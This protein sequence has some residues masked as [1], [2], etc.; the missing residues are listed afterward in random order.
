MLWLNSI[1]KGNLI[2]KGFILLTDPY[3]SSSVN[4]LKAGT[5]NQ[6]SAQRPRRSAIY[7]LAPIVCSTCFLIKTQ[8]HQSTNPKGLCH[9]HQSVIIPSMVDWRLIFWSHYL[10]CSFH[11]NDLYPE[12][13]WY[14]TAQHIKLRI[15]RKDIWEVTIL[16]AN[17][18]QDEINENSVKENILQEWQNRSQK[19]HH[20]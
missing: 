3:N 16:Y 17:Y 5:W 13:S 8:D 12:S 10:N 20:V 9:P 11:F 1:A 7:C 19:L 18:K 14:K 15:C 4:A 6:E 2:M